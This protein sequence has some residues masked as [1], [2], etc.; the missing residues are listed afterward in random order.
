MKNGCNKNRW[1]PEH[2]ATL[3]RMVEAGSNYN[4]IA[5]AVGHS[6]L[7]CRTTM[8]EIRKLRR[9]GEPVSTKRSR[10]KQSEVELLVRLIEG[11]TDYEVAAPMV[12]HRVWSCR[13]KISE[14]R[15]KRREQE[16]L[17][18]GEIAARVKPQP[19]ASPATTTEPS[20]RATSTAKLMIDAELRARLE[21]QDITAALLRDPLPGRSALDRRNQGARR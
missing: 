13:S 7:S 4:D 1:T 3:E 9:G 14:I 8:S 19:L 16:R 6:V 15:S 20:A 5:Q 12:G 17:K 2:R 21:V 18:L 10:W 11:G